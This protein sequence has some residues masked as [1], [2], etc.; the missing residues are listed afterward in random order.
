LRKIT[1]IGLLA[2]I[3]SAGGWWLRQHEQMTQARDTAFRG[4]LPDV[5]SRAEE[6]LPSGAG[7]PLRMCCTNT[8]AADG[9]FVERSWFSHPD[10]TN[11]NQRTGIWLVKN[12]Y[13]R[14]T[15]KTSSNL[16]EVT[17]HADAG[18]IDAVKPDEFVLSWSGSTNTQT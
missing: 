4:R 16:C 12:R 6:T 13:L 2:V 3:I 17:P 10:R 5:W 11:T 14:E 7:M 1:F 9:S 15:V 18:R 8:I